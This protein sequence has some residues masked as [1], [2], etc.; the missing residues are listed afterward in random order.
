MSFSVQQIPSYQ[1]LQY[2][3]KIDS[4]LKELPDNSLTQ[5]ALRA[6]ENSTQ[7]PRY[8]HPFLKEKIATLNNLYH[9]PDTPLENL[10]IF[11][12]IFK[13]KIDEKIATITKPLAEFEEE[14]QPLAEFDEDEIDFI[15]EIFH[16]F[17]PIEIQKITEMQEK[18]NLYSTRDHT[19]LGGLAETKSLEELSVCLDF[20]SSFMP[21]KWNIPAK[22]QV[23]ANL[24]LFAQVKPLKEVKGIKKLLDKLLIEDLH[25]DDRA[26]AVIFIS[27]F[28]SNRFLEDAR[29]PLMLID[30]MTPSSISERQRFDLRMSLLQTIS[31]AP[32]QNALEILNLIRESIPEGISENETFRITINLAKFVI[33]HIWVDTQTFFHFLKSIPTTLPPHVKFGIINSYALASKNRSWASIEELQ[34]EIQS[35]MPIGTSEE[36]KLIATTFWTYFCTKQG[37]ELFTDPTYAPFCAQWIL[38]AVPL[39]R[40]TLTMRTV[41]FLLDELVPPKTNNAKEAEQ[42]CEA[43]AP[44]LNIE[45]LTDY[46]ALTKLAEKCRQTIR[47]QKTSIHSS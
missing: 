26:N 12:R 40:P 4:L 47:L 19:L 20:I 6:I 8:S 1:E 46:N 43:M 18:H 9:H 41:K 10:E 14:T 22:T 32:P 5:Q 16:K 31:K 11:Q 25:P 42:L 21:N 27:R 24:C 7:L 35:H 36:K 37:G 29:E 2:R 13:E 45:I 28:F 34:Y 30:Q 3:K 17:S 44:L 38:N 39:L 33:E 15:P 23:F